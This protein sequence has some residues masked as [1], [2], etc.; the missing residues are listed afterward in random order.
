MA[1]LLLVGFASDIEAS[2]HRALNS[3]GYSILTTQTTSQA[4]QVVRDAAPTLILI[5]G[6]LPEGPYAPAA[7]EGFELC[8]AIRALPDGQRN[9]I[10]FISHQDTLDSK[11][12]GFMAGADDY[13]TIPFQ[14]TELL[15]R[16]DAL[17][18]RLSLNVMSDGAAASWVHF[19]PILLDPPTGNVQIGGRYEQLTPVESRLLAY[20]ITNAARPS[21]TEELLRHVWRLEPGT[22]DP[23][24]VRVHVRNLRAKLES[25]PTAPKLLKTSQRLGY[26]LAQDETDEPN[27]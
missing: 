11:M 3:Q 4:L 2:L 5:Y 8:H 27:C 13:I 15:L 7:N 18:R 26:Y 19:G 16:V 9:L 20:L 25:S 1:P 22:G 14:M 23:A 6:E 10:I 21:S 12:S 17:R 24:L